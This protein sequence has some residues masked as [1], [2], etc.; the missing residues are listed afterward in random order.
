MWSHGSRL[1]ASN[2]SPDAYISSAALCSTA[3]RV[4]HRRPHPPPDQL[5][6]DTHPATTDA[7][8][9]PTRL[10]RRGKQSPRAPPRLQSTPA[11]RHGNTPQTPTPAMPAAHKALPPHRPASAAPEALQDAKGLAA[12]PPLHFL[13]A[14]PPIPAPISHLPAR[15][16]PA[17]GCGLPSAPPPPSA[18]GARPLSPAA[19][20]TPHPPAQTLLLKSPLPPPA[21]APHGPSPAAPRG[22]PPHAPR[23][24]SPHSASSH[25]DRAL[26]PCANDAQENFCP[27]PRRSRPAAPHSLRSS[28]AP[29]ERRRSAGPPDAA[30]AHSS[31]RPSP[32]SRRAQ[33]PRPPPTQCPKQS[34]ALAPQHPPDRYIHPLRYRPAATAEASPPPPACSPPLPPDARQTPP[35]LPPPCG[36]YRSKQT[37]SRVRLVTGTPHSAPPA[38]AAL[39]RFAPSP[40]APLR[41]VM[42][43]LSALLAPSSPPPRARS[44]RGTRT[45]TP[46]RSA[47]L[48]SVATPATQSPLP[49]AARSSAHARSAAPNAVV[50][51]PLRV[52][53]P[54]QP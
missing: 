25:T 43:L 28:N 33:T 18:H 48:Q 12:A 11:Q 21:S 50:P 53:D 45:N 46:R 17:P 16:T 19:T 14:N 51:A 29:A 32:P 7:A 47:A 42:H 37:R 40:P 1:A 39:P 24:S 30:S 26:R 34:S 4:R 49:A 8:P 31:N 54:G 13:P 23:S 9:S 22:P 5:P 3:D 38:R 15:H 52:R 36:R 41:A 6:A 10:L 2:A 35:G 44:S 27:S 20:P